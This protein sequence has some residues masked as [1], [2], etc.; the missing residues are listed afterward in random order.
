M[1]ALL[2]IENL[3][4][5]FRLPQGLVELLMRKPHRIVKAVNGVNLK[6][7]RGET[8]GLVG[9]SGCGKTT[10]SRAML[11][12]IEI[13]SGHV[14]FDGDDVFNRKR[15]EHLALR[16]RAQMVFQDPYASLNPK[17]SVGQTLTEVYKVHRLCPWRQVPSRVA[18]LMERVGLLPE[19]GERRPGELSG[20]QC[21]RVGIARALAVSPELLV[22]DES[23]SAL[24]VSIQAQILNLFLKL[25]KEMGLTMVFIAHDLGVVWHL[26]HTIAVM[27]LGRIVEMGDAEEIF[28]TPKHP[29][30]Q[31]LIG[32]IPQMHAEAALSQDLLPGEPPSSLY[33]PSGCAFHPRCSF[34]MEVCRSGAPPEPRNMGTVKVACHLYQE[35]KR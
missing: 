12:L 19:L 1:S 21:Q 26:C 20:G 2:E 5:Q 7:K 31:A 23:V 29:Y 3:H 33:I 11:G 22:A 24:D 13:T 9:E 30:T 14:R 15:A 34:A 6:L 10:L 18:E 35:E 25:Q 17:F 4:V 27:Y 16:R 8:L 28:R 32:A